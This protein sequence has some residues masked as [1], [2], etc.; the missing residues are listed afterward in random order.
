MAQRFT[1]TWSWAPALLTEAAVRDLA[2]RWFAALE[3]LVRHAA[4]PGA[5]GR[6]PSDLPLVALSQAEIERLESA[7]PQIEDI[8]PLSPLQEGLLF[9]ALYDAQAPDIY[10]VQ[11]ELG[12][13][14]TLDERRC[15]RRRCRL[16]WRAMP[17]CA[18]ASSMRISAGRC[19]S[20][21]RRLTPPWHSI[22]L[23]S[24]DE[25]ARE[26]RLAAILA[27]DR[28]ERFDLASPPLLRCALIRLAADQHRLVLTN[29]HILMDGWSMPILV[30]ELLTLYA[31]QGDAS[32]AA[33]GHALPRLSGLD[34]G[35]GSRRRAS[36]PGGRLWPGLEEATRLAPHDP[37]RAPVAPEQ[38]TLALSETLTAALTRAGAPAGSD[39][40]HLRSRPPGR[41]CSAV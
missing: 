16:C 1:A 10:T 15:S 12:L 27:Q 38:I 11:L 18:P 31:H 32:G 39:A 40:E 28:A 23:S 3:A 25:A 17:A 19:R 2:E 34:C 33:A 24:L 29:H 9:H 35:A 21:C 13:E 37:G 8:L 41:F 6:T 30:Q 7:Y 5:G 22:D 14:G 20:S 36:R 4:A 26:E